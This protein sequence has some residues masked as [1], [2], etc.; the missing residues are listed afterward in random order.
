VSHEPAHHLSTACFIICS[1][2][3]PVYVDKF[4]QRND[5]KLEVHV[6]PTTRD[7]KGMELT[8]RRTLALPGIWQLQIE[9]S[10]IHA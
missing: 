8:N 6:H 5:Q 10:L 4:K 1:G 7:T 2:I 9:G 3:L